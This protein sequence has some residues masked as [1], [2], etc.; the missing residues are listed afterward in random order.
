MLTIGGGIQSMTLTF[1]D[2]K[3]FLCI[4]S[5]V[6]FLSLKVFSFFFDELLYMLLTC[7]PTSSCNCTES[8]S[9]HSSE[10]YRQK[11][12]YGLNLRFKII[13]Q[14][15]FVQLFMFEVSCSKRKEKEMNQDYNITTSPKILEN[16]LE[17]SQTLHVATGHILAAICY[18]FCLNG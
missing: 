6:S 4:A 11:R 5:M 18:Q 14:N 1:P 7:V 10:L 8:Q 16:I 12:K 3:Q 15:S 9:Q 2:A 13:M 17:I